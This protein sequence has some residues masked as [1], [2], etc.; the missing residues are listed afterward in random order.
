MRY[1]MPVSVLMHIDLLGPLIGLSGDEWV[2]HPRTSRT[3]TKQPGSLAWS[4][5]PLDRGSCVMTLDEYFDIMLQAMRAQ[6]TYSDSLRAWTISRT[7]AQF[8]LIDHMDLLPNQFASAPE[9]FHE[10]MRRRVWSMNAEGYRPPIVVLS[11]NDD[12]NGL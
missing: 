7:R 3:L 6:A 5:K 11:S 12:E 9:L 10:G 2:P 4:K 1:E 8:I